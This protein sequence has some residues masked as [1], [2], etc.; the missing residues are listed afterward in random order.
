MLG[1]FDERLNELEDVIKEIALEITKGA[2]VERLPPEEI[3]EKTGDQINIVKELLKEIREYLYI[4]K[5]EKVPTIQRKVTQIFEFLDIYK[6]TLTKEEGAHVSVDELRK[7]L[8]EISD[9]VSLCRTIKAEPS[10]TIQTILE[11]RENQRTEGR[12]MTPSKM[13]YLGHLVKKAQ[14]SQ[15]DLAE[16]SSTI[17]TQLE[18]VRAEYDELYFSLSQKEVEEDLE[19]LDEEP[20]EAGE[21]L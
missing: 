21:R 16:L 9:F 18:E 10:E 19:T 5:P 14:A 4:L 7:A 6:D 12:A 15:D 17:R 11:L 3:W 13:M 8:S 2:V 1:R 20:E